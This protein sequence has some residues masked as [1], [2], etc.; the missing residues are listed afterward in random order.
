MP[1]VLL[2]LFIPIL[3]LT[4]VDTIALAPRLMRVE[5]AH[6]EGSL[7]VRLHRGYIVTFGLSLISYLAFVVYLTIYFG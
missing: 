1:F 2:L 6:K 7:P 4:L 5:V 3:V